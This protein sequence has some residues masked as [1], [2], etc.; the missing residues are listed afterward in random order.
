MV[1]SAAAWEQPGSHG[2]GLARYIGRARYN[3]RR[4]EMARQRREVVY[5]LLVTYGWSTPGVLGVIAA[6]LGWSTA[7]ICRDRNMLRRS[8]LASLEHQRPRH[9]RTDTHTARTV[10]TPAP[11]HARHAATSSDYGPA[12]VASLPPGLRPTPP[13]T[14]AG[15]IALLSQVSD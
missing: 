5:E 12:G 7:T 2:E 10:A 8:L 1:I 9:R 11:W 3:L 14:L 4:Q 15:P 13:A 6:E